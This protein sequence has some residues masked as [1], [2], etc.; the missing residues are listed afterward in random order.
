[1]D[2]LATGGSDVAVAIRQPTRSLARPHV[3]KR[4]PPAGS[5]NRTLIITYVR[6]CK[7]TQ[8]ISV[9]DGRVAIPTSCCVN[10]GEQS[11][12]RLTS[13]TNR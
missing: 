2:L 3:R 8:E 13:T 6:T 4:I 9:G 11:D 10:D 1:M 7:A 5:G 12:L